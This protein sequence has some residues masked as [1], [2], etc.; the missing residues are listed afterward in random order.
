MDPA[1]RIRWR[2]WNAGLNSQQPTKST[3]LNWI[4]KGE[5]Y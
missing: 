1:T 5:G 4:T 3:S 2:G